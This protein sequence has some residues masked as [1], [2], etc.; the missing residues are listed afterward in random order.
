MTLRFPLITLAAPEPLPYLSRAIATGADAVDQYLFVDH[1]GFCEQIGTALVV[2]LRELG[3]PARLAVGYTPGERNPF[4]G[5]YEV[6]ASD[7]HAW[8]ELYFEG[9]GW[10]RFEPTPGAR[11]GTPPP[12]AVLGAD[13]GASR[14]GREVSET[15]TG[16]FL[17]WCRPTAR[18]TRAPTRP[19]ANAYRFSRCLLWA[20]AV[21]SR[22]I[23]RSCSPGSC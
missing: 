15:A 19:R 22:T 4:T 1:K 5:L 23:T 7:A 14:G 18:R 11:S 16:S 13:A 21:P 6:K 3:V 17:V 20:W 12:Y 9:Y 10:L 8:P 2:M